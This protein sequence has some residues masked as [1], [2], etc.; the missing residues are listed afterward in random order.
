MV[1]VIAVGPDVR[2]PG[3]ALEKEFVNT[4]DFNN[5]QHETSAEPGR[6]RREPSQ[7]MAVNWVLKEWRGTELRRFE[8]GSGQKG[9]DRRLPDFPSGSP[10]ISRA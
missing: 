1:V 4:I 8:Y 9:C 5:R 10:K 3:F 2:M 6:A 7:Q